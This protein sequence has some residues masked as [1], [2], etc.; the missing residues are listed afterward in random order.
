MHI[1]QSG[2]YIWLENVMACFKLHRRC[3][4]PCA[5]HVYVAGAALLKRQEQTIA[6]CL[7]A[8]MKDFLLA[9]IRKKAFT[10]VDNWTVYQHLALC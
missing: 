2:A 5:R 8:V 10:L 7:G 1:S 4:I 3:E 6:V 9:G